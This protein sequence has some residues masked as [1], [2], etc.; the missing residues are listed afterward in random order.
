MSVATLR[1]RGGAT[2]AGS[3]GTT[4]TGVAGL[5]L[6]AASV[7]VSDNTSPLCA[8][9]VATKLP[10]AVAVTLT[11]RPVWVLVSHTWALASTLPAAPVTVTWP[12][13]TGPTVTEAGL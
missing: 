7:L 1:S 4:V 10:P 5:V 11:L 12:F 2:V 6:P 8:A 9:I 3:G 13:V